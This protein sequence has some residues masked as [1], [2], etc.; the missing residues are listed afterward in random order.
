[1]SDFFLGRR[2]LSFLY[3]SLLDGVQFTVVWHVEVYKFQLEHFL[4]TFILTS[5]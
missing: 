3:A 4:N 1:M 5:K 2:L